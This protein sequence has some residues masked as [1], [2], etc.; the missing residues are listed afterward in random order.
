MINFQRLLFILML[1]QFIA[2]HSLSQNL[3]INELMSTNSNTLFDEDNDSPDWIEITNSGTSTVNL[4]DYYLSDDSQDLFKWQF[5]D[6]N[7]EPAQQL[8]VF[9]SDKDRPQVPLHWNSIVDVGDSWKYLLP[10][11]EP[12][13]TW[14]QSGFNDVAWNTGAS[15]IGYSDN[16]DNT[17]VPYGTMSVFMRIKF[18]LSDVENI[19]SMW[20]HMDYDDGFVAYLNNTEIARAGLGQAGSQVSYNQQASS[21]EARIYQGQEPENFNIS[22]YTYLLKE[23]DNVLAVQV[24]NTATN[25]SDLSSIPILTIGSTQP[26]GTGSGPSDYV[27]LPT[28]F[29]HANFKLSSTGETVYLTD[30]NGTITDSVKYD[31]IPSELSFGRDINNIGNW[32]YFSEPTPGMPNNSEFL[33]DVVKGEVQFS[34]TSMFV[35]PYTYISLSGAMEGEEIR[36]TEN[37]EEPTENSSKYQFGIQIDKNKVIRARIFKAGAVPGKI[38]SRTFLVDNKPT[39]PVVSV[40]TDPENLWNNETGIHV[41]GDSYENQNPYFGANFWEDWEKPANIEMADTG[42]NLLFTLNCGIKIY[43]AWSRARDQK[44]LAIHFRKEYGDA[45]LENVQL[46]DTKPITEFKS[47]VL[48]NAGNDYDYTRFRDGMMTSLVSKMDNDIMAIRPAIVYLNG[49]YWGH[50]NLR[51]K[52]N[53]DFIESNHG[54]N[55]DELDLLENNGSI[56]EGSSDGYWDLV[57]FLE[58]N[59]MSND[60]NYNYVAERIDISNFIDYFVS[61]IYFD[62]RD[63]PGNNVKFWK[64]QAEGGKWRWIMYDTDFGFGLYDNSAF[65]LNTFEFATEPYGPGWP[66]PP[67]STLFLRKLLENQNFRRAF[68]NRFADMMNTTFLS[69]PIIERIDSMAAILEPEIPGH[70]QKWGVP[71]IYWWQQCNENMKVFAQNRVNYLRNHIKQMYDSPAYHNLVLSTL[72]TNSGTVQLNSLHIKNSSWKGQY[73]KN[74]PITLTAHSNKGFRFHS[75]KVNGVS[76][77][78]ETIELDL[79]QATDVQVIFEASEDDGKTIVINEINYNSE[80]NSDAG[81][82]VEFYNWGQS[83]IDMSGWIFKDNSDDHMFVI[84][85]NTVLKSKEYLVLCRASEDFQIIHPNVKNYIGDMDFGLTSAGD[86][87]RLFDDVGVLIDSLTFG[88]DLPWPSEPN[89][90]GPTLELRHYAY[91]NS[92]ATSWKASLV[93]LG[94]PGRENSITTGIDWLAGNNTVKQLKVYPNPFSDQVRIEVQNNGFNPMKVQ[95][96]TLDGRLVCNENIFADEFLWKGE[97]SS[98]IKLQPGIY[99]CKVQSGGE[100]F[101]EKIILSR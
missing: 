75:W 39:L 7:L 42:G 91:N 55:A 11:S 56:L 101:T 76:M 24:H 97:N 100:I 53:E 71:N 14:K 57:Y 23:N 25:S 49:E 80:V 82:W 62:N 1:S 34:Y 15:G 83:D 37:G 59:D 99:I 44:S 90:T 77:L 98:G 72:P 41:L 94:T 9:A 79:N 43:G 66:N 29:P 96:F 13:S 19:Q 30:K 38:T 22:D 63:W 10:T 69:D 78:E 58:N 27:S 18:S 40:I 28:L 3:L 73:F 70:A 65:V 4:A 89:G 88:S 85:E 6:F 68:I 8:L 64:P 54:V 31:I 20:L 12:S 45:K 46:F 61:E 93:N 21:H 32:G 33:T 67:W 81:D 95:I 84:P 48:R 52:I 35:S 36:Y 17:Q 50:M 86:A 5:P 51:E 87:V 60:A 74:Y 26:F 47:L 92:E 16:D 2:N